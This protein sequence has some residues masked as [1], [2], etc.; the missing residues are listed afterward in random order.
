MREL[1]EQEVGAVSGA[2]CDYAAIAAGAAVIGLGIMI[3]STG[4]LAGIAVPIIM[5]A[6]TGMEIGAAA[7]SVGLSG[8]GGSL[9]GWGVTSDG[10]S[11]KKQE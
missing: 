1:T 9:I 5:G 8:F 2:C 4:G 3:A 7:V 10:G 11:E 6:G